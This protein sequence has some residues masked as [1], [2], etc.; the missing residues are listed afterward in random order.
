MITGSSLRLMERSVRT[1]SFEID[2]IL[3]PLGVLNHLHCLVFQNGVVAPELP[4]FHVI[5]VPLLSHV[6]WNI[7][8]DKGLF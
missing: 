7:M 5:F 4:N 6:K 1:P 8:F 2:G 3:G